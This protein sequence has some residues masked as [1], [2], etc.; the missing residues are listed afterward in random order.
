M[1]PTTTEPIVQDWISAQHTSDQIS[2]LDTTANEHLDA[3]Q[4]TTAAAVNSLLACVEVADLRPALVP[5]LAAAAAELALVA[6]IA[7]RFSDD[8]AP[9]ALLRMIAKVSIR[10]PGANGPHTLRLFD[11]LR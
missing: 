8:D 10:A 4:G 11:Q 3:A 5:Y 2:G 9:V 7:W 6:G 1:T